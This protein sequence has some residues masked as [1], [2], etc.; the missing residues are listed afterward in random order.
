MNAEKCLVLGASGFLGSHLCEALIKNKQKVRAYSRTQKIDANLPSSIE[1]ITG[2]FLSSQN[3]HEAVYGCDVIYHLISSTV[4]ATSNLDPM[5]DVQCN[6]IGT[7]KLLE[8]AVAEKVRKIVFVSS[9]G[10]I[11]GIPTFLPIKE[12]MPTNPIC[13]YGIS[14][15][16]IEKYLYMY[17]E[18]YGLDYSI[19]R[20]SNPYGEK[21]SATKIQGVIPVFMKKILDQ[22]PVEI[23]GD[24]EVVRDYIYVHD[25][26]DA[27]LKAK[28]YVGEQRIFNIGS[29]NGR[30]LNQVL[31]S[32]EKIMDQKVERLYKPQRKIDVPTIMLDIS[33][34]QEHLKWTPQIDWEKGLAKTHEWIRQTYY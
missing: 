23:W 1:W 17:S 33:L 26:I 14:K 15:L 3:L 12:N 30:S 16:T 25:V 32:L 18:L 20:L 22:E 31:L 6:V 5:Y 9:A 19:L 7:L 11:Y 34:A 4:P 13:S 8:I 10:T 21:Q 27:L 2:D 24:G 29:G 28:E